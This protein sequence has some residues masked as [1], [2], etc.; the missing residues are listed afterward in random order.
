MANR[1]KLIFD[2]SPEEKEWLESI[3]RPG[4]TKISLLR[5][6]MDEYASKNKLPARPG[7]KEGK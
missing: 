1:A 4:Q 7:L 5:Q 2:V 3:L 6:W